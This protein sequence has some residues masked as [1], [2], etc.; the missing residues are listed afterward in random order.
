MILTDDGRVLKV[1]IVK[2]SSSQY[3]SNLLEEIFISPREQP[4]GVVNM[5]VMR[6]QQ[7]GLPEVILVNTNSTVVE[8]PLQRCDNLTE[9]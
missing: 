2:D 7:Q 5:E 4:E 8:L 1:V 3:R 6:P 9:W